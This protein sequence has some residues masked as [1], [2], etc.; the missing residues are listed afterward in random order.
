MHMFV[1]SET[2]WEI[3]PMPDYFAGENGQRYSM[4]VDAEQQQ[5]A[6]DDY[7]YEQATVETPAAPVRPTMAPSAFAARQALAKKSNSS[8]A[9]IQAVLHYRIPRS[10]FSATQIAV[11]V[12]YVLIN[13]LCVT[14]VDRRNDGATRVG[15]LA[16]ANMLI[17]A[18]PA[19]RNSVLVWVL[20]YSFDTV[21]VFHRWIGRLLLL[22]VSI[23]M[24]AWYALWAQQGLSIYAMQFSTASYTRGFVAWVVLVVV[25]ILSIDFFRR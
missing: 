23:H 19:T 1:A 15:W 5:A 3:P 16:T 6:Y 22:L 24:F 25:N 18:V 17:V 2:A 21:M 14:L 8:F 20:G 10:Q 7:E 4:A 11:F 12:A 9:R 13:V